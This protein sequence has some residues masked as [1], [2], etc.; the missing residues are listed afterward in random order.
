MTDDTPDDDSSDTT[1]LMPTPGGNLYANAYDED[2]DEV[3]ETNERQ[4]KI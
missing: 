4:Q 1:I 2:M 3:V